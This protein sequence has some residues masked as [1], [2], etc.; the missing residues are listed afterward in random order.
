MAWI[1]THS[2]QMASVRYM[3][4]R[5]VISHPDYRALNNGYA[6]NLALVRLKKKIT[7]SKDVAPVTL[8]SSTDASN[9]SSDCWI[10]GWGYIGTDGMFCTFIDLYVTLHT[11]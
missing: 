1:G 10:T 2:L 4:I 7:F 5:Y 3:G 11:V 6:N 8:P 9:P